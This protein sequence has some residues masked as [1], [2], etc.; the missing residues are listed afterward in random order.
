ML[1]RTRGRATPYVEIPSKVILRVEI[2]SPHMT[3]IRSPGLWLLSGALLMLVSV[4]LAEFLYPEYSVSQNYI[5]DLGVGPMPSRGIFT[6]GIIVF[7]LVVLISAA[8]MRQTFPRSSMWFLLAASGVGAIGVGIIN[9]DSFLRVHALFAAMAFLFGN[10]AAVYSYRMVRPP[11]SWVFVLLGLI[12][13]SA[14]ALTGGEIFLGIGAGGMERM[15]FYPA[16]FWILAFGAYLLG[17]EDKGQ[18]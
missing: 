16:M 7:G 15:I 9:E 10:L 11:L 5:S 17:L 8:M 14:L 1:D 13:L 12:G 3:R 4:H 18:G 6:A 2:D